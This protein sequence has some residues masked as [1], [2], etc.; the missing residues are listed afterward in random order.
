MSCI[1]RRSRR[2]AVV[3][4]GAVS[5]SGCA[6]LTSREPD[7]TRWPGSLVGSWQ[8]VNDDTEVWALDAGG[9]LRVLEVD[10]PR[11][12]ESWTGSWWTQAAGPSGGRELCYVR[13]HGRNAWCEVYDLVVDPA[14]GLGTTLGFS[15]RTLRR[16]SQTPTTS[17]AGS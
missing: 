9:R 6:A 4:L 8:A 11:E 1:S 17:G 15:G 7:P 12:V 10:G 13:R 3:L 14:S 16:R 2:A 5:L